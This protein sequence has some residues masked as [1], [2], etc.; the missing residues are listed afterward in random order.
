MAM[1]ERIGF[2]GL[3]IMGSR[4]A[5][6][7]ARAGFELAVWNRTSATAVTW[8][9]EHRASV[10]ASPADLARSSDLVVTMVVDGP[11]VEEVL[12]GPCGV[13]AGARPGLLCVDC[14]TIGPAA[15]RRIGARLADE[16][17]SLVDAPVTGSSPR[18]QDGT[19]TIMAGGTAEDFGRAEPTLRA[20]GRLVLHVGELGDGQTIKLINNAVAAAN[21]ATLA[22]ALVLAAAAGVDLDALC[23]VMDAGSGGSV[24]LSAKQAAMRAHDYTP[25]FKLEHMLKDV[26]LCLEEAAAAGVPFAAATRAADLLAAGR[27]VGYANDDYAAILEVVERAAGR[28]L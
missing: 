25:L 20:M 2:I 26:R 21:A 27:E 10:A 11:Q 18:A 28:R 22:E 9:A 24:A 15:T 5:A 23:A 4:M 12:L 7:V 3:G 14:S 6:N 19:L 8:A 1:P 13:A 17:L 16:G